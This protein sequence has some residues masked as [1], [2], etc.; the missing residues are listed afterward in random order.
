MSQKESKVLRCII[1][2][3][4][5][6]I[7]KL[8]GIKILRDVLLRT[9][10]VILNIRGIKLLETLSLRVLVM[11]RKGGKVQSHLIIESFKYDCQDKGSVT[12]S[13]LGR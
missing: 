2:R 1:T 4:V 9:L 8:R 13:E 6:M 5:S 12:L 10:N 7:V 3:F 11:L